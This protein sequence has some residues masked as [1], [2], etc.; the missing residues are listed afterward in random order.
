M[1][2]YQI[3]LHCYPKSFR[4][5]YGQEL[6]RAF[7][8]KTRGY[9]A[10]RQMFAAIAD[11]IA[12]APHLHWEIL[13]QDLHFAARSL[14]RAPSFSLTVVLVTAIG[15]GANTATFS[16]ADR[17][18][19]R[20]LPF[21]A[22]DEI[23]RLC[24]GPREGGGWGCNNQISPSNFRDV[25]E[26]SHSFSALGAFKR[27]AVNLLGVGAPT[28]VVSAS[29]AGEILPMLGVSPEM[30]RL[31][32]VSDRADPSV[33]VISHALWQEQ[34]GGDVSIVGRTVRLDGA[35][36]VIV[37]VMP[38]EFSFPTAETRLWR[39]LVITEADASDRANNILEGIGR[40]RP[41]VS[42]EQAFT[43]I[44][45]IAGQLA[46]E[47]P[48]TNRETGFSFFRQRDEMSPRF[49]MI[50]LALCGASLSLL[51]LTMANLGSLHLTRL[52]SREK[53][54]A[55]RAA[56]GAGRERLVRQM[57]TESTLLALV[58]GVVGLGVGI[59]TVPLL[60]H[61]VP[62]TLPLAEHGAIDSRIFIVAALVTAAVGI[63]VGVIPAWRAGQRD[64]FTTLRSGVGGGGRRQRLRRTLV[65]VEIAVS[66]V[67]LT[68]SAFLIRAVWRVQD[69]Q[70]GFAVADAISMRTALPETRYAKPSEKNAFYKR[71]LNEVKQLPG[72][73]A[74]GYTSGLP[75]EMTGGITGA[76][77]PGEQTR[78]TQ[79][80][81]VSWRIVT[82][83]YF[84]AI[85]VALE[86]GRD[87]EWVDDTTRALVAVVS[88]SFAE[89]YWPGQDA[90]GREF[91][92]RQ[93]RRIVVGIVRDIRV[94]GLERTSEPQMYLPAGQSPD[95]IG[96]FYGPKDL[97]I[98]SHG[99]TMDLVP[100]VRGIVSRIDPDQPISNVRPLS[101][102][103]AGQSVAR[104][105]QV[106]VL[107][108]LALVALLLTAVGIHGLLA[109]GVAQR[110]REIGLRLALGADRRQVAGLVTGEALQ[111]ALMGGL[112]GL[113][114]AFAAVRS[115][116][117]MLFGLEPA[118]PF[119]LSGAAFVV[120]LVAVAGSIA[121]AARAVRVSPMEA[122]R[123][124]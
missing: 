33:L 42:F 1:R 78:T 90:I 36:H 22:P 85:G 60:A 101:E 100:A 113:V 10:F 15:V 56:L 123:S 111:L 2:F 59:F 109:Y 39:P 20:P 99:T 80:A 83:G 110:S 119:M 23:V 63:G 3:L 34:F 53:E 93:K 71:V 30:G 47:Y 87:V 96:E 81:T 35:P 92:M 70:P 121:P 64:V 28:R 21:R 45:G 104:L 41:G 103:V 49:R 16:V 17:V 88:N 69:V 65:S 67:L 46:K 12:N 8:A 108:A 31:L 82:P 112:P 61:L 114:I 95:S 27:N 74:A 18:L 106:R 124:E 43:E 79:N 32:N 14:R 26:R 116:R 91:I 72:V 4:L 66:V 75:M 29:V 9:G 44:K 50:L 57:L 38:P 24:E 77:L 102:V 25:A 98:R 58:G 107:G 54:L 19:L 76:I 52:A 55:V 62:S 84:A 51:L 120:V 7:E 48:E 105:A 117:A 73:E 6:Q 118:D 89:R 86:H 5:H 40:L 97:V 13:R 94:R 122:M 37:G 11:V 115:M 68:A